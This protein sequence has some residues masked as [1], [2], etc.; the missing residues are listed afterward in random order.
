MH[1]S[2]IELSAFLRLLGCRDAYRR[3]YQMRAEPIPVLELL[4]QH[5]QV[6]RSV[7]RCLTR[8]GALLRETIAPE[9]LEHVRRTA[10]HRRAHRADQAH[11]L[12]GLRPRR[13]GGRSTWRPTEQPTPGAPSQDE[14]EPLLD[15]LLGATL[16][17][18]TLS[19][20]AS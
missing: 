14:L 6:P 20:T 2:E 10:R 8:C 16:G 9:L 11:R 15:E 7:L 13:A 5:P 1:A 19:P 4:W 12:A 3:I 18:H 17:I